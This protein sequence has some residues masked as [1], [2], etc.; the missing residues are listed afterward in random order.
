VVTFGHTSR[1]TLVGVLTIFD[2]VLLSG[3]LV[4]VIGHF[5]DEKPLT[6]AFG[7][8]HCALVAAQWCALNDMVLE[9]LLRLG[10]R[11]RRATPILDDCVGATN[12]AG[13]ERFDE[14][15]SQGEDIACR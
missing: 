10:Q 1:G 5:V 2:I 9:S 12:T 13:R 3:L 14:P 8:G 7:V 15:V 6:I 4:V 11:R